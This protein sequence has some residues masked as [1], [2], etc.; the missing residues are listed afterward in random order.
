MSHS[1][2]QCAEPPSCKCVP[3]AAEERMEER[4]EERIDA[5]RRSFWRLKGGGGGGLFWT[6][7]NCI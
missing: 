6:G 1:L 7:V 5:N 4:M 2:S 3:P